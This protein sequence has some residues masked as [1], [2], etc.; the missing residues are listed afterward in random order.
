MLRW[1]SRGLTQHTHQTVGILDDYSS[2]SKGEDSEDGTGSTG[3]GTSK[4]K[5]SDP[6]GA[7]R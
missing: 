5:V 6:E 2:T 7:E 1:P 3:T 4:L